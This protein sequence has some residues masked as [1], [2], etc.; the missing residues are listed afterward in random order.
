[1]RI[2]DWSSDVCS[3]DLLPGD[4]AT[5]AAGVTP[6]GGKLV[7]KNVSNTELTYLDHAIIDMEICTQAKWFVGFTKST[8]SLTVTFKRHW[9]DPAHPRP[10]YHYNWGNITERHDAG[11][12]VLRR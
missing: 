6:W 10:S 8:F 5:L 4:A 1:M 11:L 9:L 7:R 2:S 3:S 12:Q